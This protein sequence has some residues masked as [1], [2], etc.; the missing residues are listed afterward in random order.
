LTY[1][2]STAA[3][4]RAEEVISLGESG[5]RFRLHL[6]SARREVRTP[7]L[8]RHGVHN[9]LAAA[10][11]AIVAGMTADD[12]VAGLAHEIDVP[13]RSQLVRAGEWT[14]LDDS[15]N[16]SPDAVEAA[17]DLLAELPG[18]AI[19]VLGE[20]SELGDAA[21]AEHLRV[22]RYA[23]AH[24]QRLLL[25]GAGAQGIADGAIE[26]GMAPADIDVVADRDDALTL[27]LA[28]LRPGDRVLVKASRAAALDLLVDR[29]VLA[30]R[31]GATPA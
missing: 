4:V 10:A 5:M 28:Q 7:V 12:I 14:I 13:H 3:D 29:L 1:G 11:V 17:L 30:A 18:R 15:Y 21:D 2:F 9:A 31:A 22:G 24:S 8:G 23:A 16:A 27:L 26:A 25:V 20:M 19:A 6:P